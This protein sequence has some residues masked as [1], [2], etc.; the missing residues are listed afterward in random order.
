MLILFINNCKVQK[1]R[2][3]TEFSKGDTV[4]AFLKMAQISYMYKFTELLNYRAYMHMFYP[5]EFQG[6]GIN[7]Y[8]LQ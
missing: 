4:K 8:S 5:I 3:I 7:I 1:M 2:F 6:S